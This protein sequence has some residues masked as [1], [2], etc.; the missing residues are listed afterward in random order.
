MGYFCLPR[1]DSNIDLI[2]CAIEN[3]NIW[4]KGYDYLID[5]FALYSINKVLNGTIDGNIQSQLLEAESTLQLFL[6]HQN[7]MYLELVLGRLTSILK[8]LNATENLS[9]S[10]LPEGTIQDS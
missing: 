9:A 6:K 8:E 1:S 3:I 10:T 7:P 5:T 2:K 4:H